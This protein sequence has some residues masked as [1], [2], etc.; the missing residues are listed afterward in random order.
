MELED[1]LK[2]DELKP[3]ST[4]YTQVDNSATEVKEEKEIADTKKEEEEEITVEETTVQDE[5]IE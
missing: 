2:L 1:F 3:L 4:S 5:K